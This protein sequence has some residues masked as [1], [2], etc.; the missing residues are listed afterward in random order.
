MTEQQR[1]HS[2]TSLDFTTALSSRTTNDL[3]DS[4]ISNSVL[5]SIGVNTVSSIGV[6]SENYSQSMSLGLSRYLN[7]TSSLNISERMAK[8]AENNLSPVYMYSS[9]D[10][11][12]S[13]NQRSLGCE[14]SVTPVRSSRSFPSLNKAGSTFT[15]NKDESLEALELELQAVLRNIED[16][17]L[18]QVSGVCF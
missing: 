12:K 18:P 5:S 17:L 11:S 4:K 9:S 10:I 8:L 14:Y 16:Y 13:L 15:L 7:V 1:H 6:P 3:T 2:T